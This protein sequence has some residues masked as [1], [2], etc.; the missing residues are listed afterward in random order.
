MSASNAGW[1]SAPMGVA[2]VG[3]GYWGPNLARNFAKSDD[4]RLR[5]VCDL[6]QSRAAKVAAGTGAEVTDD[7]DEVLADD[8]TVAV[9]IATP[10]STHSELAL[11]AIGASKH[12][13]VEKPLAST[14]A[15]GEAI[16]KAAHERGVA[17]MCDHTFCYTPAV[18]YLKKAVDDGTLGDIQYFDSVRVNLGLVQRDIDVLWD[19]APHD[20]SILDYVLPD[21]LRPIA[22]AAHGADP[23]GAGQACVA[24]LTLQLPKGAIAHVHVNWL[25]PIKVRMTMVGG[26][27]RTA[28]WDDLDAVARVAVFDRGVDLQPIESLDLETRAKSRIAYR[29]GDMHAPALAGGEALA[30]MVTEFAAAI[31]EG[32]A[33]RTDGRAGLRVLDILE[34]AS[35]SL[36]F[37]GTVVP[38][39]TGR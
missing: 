2:V 8:D 29:T 10:A 36:E 25:S 21:G 19:L 24:Y 3:A 18:E 22:V 38:L 34:A 13:L 23:I 5:W 15:D 12:V 32:R 26:S 17:L 31:N 27:R 4:W 37:K 1:Q 16:V 6:D 33:P 7:L 39:R 28:I 30:G 11:R 35:R 20:L 14:Y 9:A